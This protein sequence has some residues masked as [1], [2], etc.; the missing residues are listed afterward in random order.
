MASPVHTLPLDGWSR[1][2]FEWDALQSHNE[3]QHQRYDCERHQNSD[4]CEFEFAT[5]LEMQE[6]KSDRDFGDERAG[7]VEDLIDGI[8]F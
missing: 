8:P 3:T 4:Q 6:E 7:D 2:S 1:Q 5:V